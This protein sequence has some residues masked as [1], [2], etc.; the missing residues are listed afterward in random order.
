MGLPDPED[1]PCRRLRELPALNDAEN[2]EREFGFQ[3]LAFRIWKAEVSK[4]VAATAFH[5]DSGLFPHFNSAFLG[6]LGL[7]PQDVA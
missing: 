3:L 5:L 4:Y 7:L 6:S 1:L 2:L